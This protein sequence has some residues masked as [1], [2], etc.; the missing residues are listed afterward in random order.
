MSPQ[1]NLDSVRAYLDGPNRAVLATLGPTGEPHVVVVDYLVLDD[2]LLLNGRRGRRWVANLRRDPRA[3]ALIHDPHAVEHW[4]SV[5]GSVELAARVTTPP[6]RTRRRCRG[7]MGTIP[8]SSTDNTGSRGASS[9]SESS[10]GPPDTGLSGPPQ[11]TDPVAV[12]GR[13]EFVAPSRHEAG[14]GSLAWS[15]RGPWLRDVR[16]L[17]TERPPLR[18]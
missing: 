14:T 10:K 15:P 7:A 16:S 12:S 17:Q 6:S 4:V 3:T 2:A 18:R 8:S 5:G 13:I 9:L 11:V 1:V